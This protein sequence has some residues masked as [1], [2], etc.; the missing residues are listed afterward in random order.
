MTKILTGICFIKLV[1]EGKV[2]LSDPICDI[3][4]E[5]NNKKPI[6]KMD[7]SLVIVIAVK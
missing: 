7:V 2:S 4:P 6:E 1:E 3:F 5:F